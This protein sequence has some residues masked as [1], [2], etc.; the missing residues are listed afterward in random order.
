MDEHSLSHESVRKI[1][2]DLDV[3]PET[4]MIGRR[5]SCH[6]NKNVLERLFKECS[7][8]E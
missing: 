6:I 1:P 4:G 5:P 8:D 7:D 3:D 2:D